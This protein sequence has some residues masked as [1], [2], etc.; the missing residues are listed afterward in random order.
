MERMF[1]DLYF[2]RRRLFESNILKTV[3]IETYISGE[4][5]TEFDRKEKIREYK[6]KK[7]KTYR[8]FQKNALQLIYKH[9]RGNIITCKIMITIAQLVVIRLTL[10]IYLQMY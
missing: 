5:L 4:Q 2:H 9:H 3:R 7:L 10:M 6:E 8:K 1:T